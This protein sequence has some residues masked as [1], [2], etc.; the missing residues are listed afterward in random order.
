VVSYAP[1]QARIVRL[2]DVRLKDVRLR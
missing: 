1:E 2:I